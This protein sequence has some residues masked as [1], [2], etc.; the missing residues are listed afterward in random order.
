M[1]K[2]KRVLKILTKQLKEKLKDGLWGVYLFGSLAKG[3]SRP[4]SDID[5]LVIYSGIEERELLRL[6]SELTFDLALKEGD[7]IETVPMHKDEYER[8]LGRSPFLWEVLK[9]GKPIFTKL[10]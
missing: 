5:V 2:G 9:F 1:T 6:T 7:L 8:S 3:L 4:E 10:S